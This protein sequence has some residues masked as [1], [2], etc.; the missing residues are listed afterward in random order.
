[1]CY[2]PNTIITGLINETELI[3]QHDL[4]V[5]LVPFHPFPYVFTRFCLFLHVFYACM[6]YD[7]NTIITGLINETELIQQ[8]DLHV[9]LVPFHPFPYVFTRFCLFLHVFNLCMHVLC[10]EYNYNRFN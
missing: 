3:Q 7:P 5:R 9:R 10:P 2:D 6:C 8:H 4:H 1:M